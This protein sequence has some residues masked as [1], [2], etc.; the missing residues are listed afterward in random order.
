MRLAD[1][2]KRAA[3]FIRS[4]I[5]SDPWQLIF[6][7]GVIFLL[8][9]P[10]LHWP[11]N[12]NKFFAALWSLGFSQRVAVTDLMRVV[13]ILLNLVTFGALAGYAACFWPG[14]KPVRRVLLSVVLP[15]LLSLTI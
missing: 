3:Q 5:P 12:L 9:S 14:D 2:L 10:R 7:A 6:L 4:V 13:N 11:S 1:M 15:T 8:I